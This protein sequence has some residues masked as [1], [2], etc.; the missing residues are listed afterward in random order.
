M[1]WSFRRRIKII[2]GVYLNVSKRGV[3]TTVGVRGASLTFRDDGTYANVGV[4][5]TGIYNRQK[6]SGRRT[7]STLP[8]PSDSDSTKIRPIPPSPV[9]A[10]DYEYI[11]SDPLSIS[12]EGLRGFQLAVIE[13]NKQSILLK[14]DLESVR[15]SKLISL[16][17]SVFLKICLLYF[18]I[19]Q[20]KR[21]IDQ[22]VFGQSQAILQVQEAIEKS[23]VPLEVEMD[24]EVE[25]AYK[26][27]I[28][29]FED[30]MKSQF[31]WDVTSASDIDRVK[32]RSAAA[33]SVT[34]RRT[35]FGLNS[36][37]GISSSLQSI[38]LKNLNGADIF[39]YPGFFVM[40]SDLARL[41]VVDLADLV[42]S[43]S[44][45]QFVENETVPADSR[46]VGEVWERSNKDGSRDKRYAD[47][48]LIPLMEYGEI[49]FKSASGVFE[50][51][52]ISN[53]SSA[54]KFVDAMRAFSSSIFT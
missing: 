2:P 12:S 47:N 46:Q 4:P 24:S 10:P 21:W 9:L 31:I 52:M 6:I 8:L 54:S 38:H 43:F 36:V 13:G 49:T 19:P 17:T 34:R 51:F 11:S 44:T 25:S 45:T 26:R 39:I 42:I 40:F 53:A 48:K 27:C 5:G 20:L 16:V 18:L 30:L 32:T 29:C 37:P 28:S 1:G 15:A 23:S 7:N 33:L 3:S 35:A 14:K 22:R 41:G 50:K